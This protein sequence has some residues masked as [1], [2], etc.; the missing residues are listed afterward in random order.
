VS[1]IVPNCVPVKVISVFKIGEAELMDKAVTVG[2]SELSYENVKLCLTL[3]TEMKTLAPVHE[4]T[5]AGILNVISSLE[6]ER[7]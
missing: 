6:T 1:L 2:V 4:V 7:N 5:F 3:F